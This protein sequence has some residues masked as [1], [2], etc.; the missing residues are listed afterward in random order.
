MFREFAGVA[1]LLVAGL[2]LSPRGMAQI[3]TVPHSSK[4]P[5]PNQV[6]PRY[7]QGRSAGESSSHDTKIDLSPPKDDAKDHPFSDTSDPD[8][9]AD[10]PGD[11]QEVHPWDPHKAAKDIEVGDF[12][13]K[14]KSYGA[15]LA[16]YQDALLWKDNDAEA[17]FR[18]GQC[19]EKVNN[20]TEAAAHYQTYLKILPYG[21]YAVEAQK[22]L[23]RL[24]G[25]V[26]AATT[27]AQFV[28]S[29]GIDS[30]H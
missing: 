13:F 30:V 4:A 17:N 22:A 11:T 3:E 10:T 29:D 6:P 14:R 24:K 5:D 25:K 8:A 7:D 16:R 15:A 1:V 2:F 21:P 23:D 20:P 28:L 12:Y 27:K 18:L 26:P 9:E 19:F